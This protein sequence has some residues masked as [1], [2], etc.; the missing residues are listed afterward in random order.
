MSLLRTRS[1]DVPWPDESHRGVPSRSVSTAVFAYL[2]A[3]A[4]ACS[5]RGLTVIG[6]DNAG[7]DGHWSGRLELSP[8]RLSSGYHAAVELRWSE[9]TGWEVALRQ[10]PDP[11]ALPWRFLHVERT[12]AAEQVAAFLAGLLR[13]EDLGMVY[14][15]RFREDGTATELMA[16]LRRHTDDGSGGDGVNAGPA[17]RED[18]E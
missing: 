12:P 10:R 1:P 2:R 8:Q 11:E 14:P 3:V 15:A 4:A 13:G 5:D 16:E 9:R 7:T 18:D 17:R 6:V